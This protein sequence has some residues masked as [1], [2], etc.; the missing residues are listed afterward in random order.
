MIGSVTN[1]TLDAVET[2][3]N[4]TRYDLV[5]AVIPLAFLFGVVASNLGS[6]SLH[7]G[8]AIAAAVGGL[9]VVDALFV[10]PPSTGGPGD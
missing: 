7:G 5:L 10:N 3:S 8:M 9:A 4:L 1:G 6:V 2:V